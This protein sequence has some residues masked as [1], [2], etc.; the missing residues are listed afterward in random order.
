MSVLF[1]SRDLY[2]VSRYLSAKIL[3]RT[4]LF[5]RSLYTSKLIELDCLP[6]PIPSTTKYTTGVF[7]FDANAT[8]QSLGENLFV[9]FC[10]FGPLYVSMTTGNCL[11]S[12]TFHPFGPITLQ[13]RL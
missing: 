7:L 2:M 9:T 3:S 13:L 12:P 11:A 5:P 10:E 1:G 8:D 4:S 6:D